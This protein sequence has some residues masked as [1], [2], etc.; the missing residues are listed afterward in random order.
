MANKLKNLNLTSVDLVRRG[1]NQEADICLFKSDLAQDGENPPS[2]HERNIFKQFINWLRKNPAEGDSTPSD[3]IEKDYSTFDA[4]NANRENQEKL[5]Q[6]TS[7]LTESIRTIVDDNSLD[8]AQKLEFMKKSLGQFDTAMEK[9][10][11]SL[12][13]M[14][15]VKQNVPD[16]VVKADS[17]YRYDVIQ[18]VKKFNPYHGKD[19][20]FS[21]ASGGGAT[22]F[23]IRTKDPN[24]QH[25]ADKAMMREAMRTTSI[26]VNGPSETKAFVDDYIKKHPEVAEEAKKYKDVLENVKN[27]QK[28]NPNAEAGTYSAVTGELVNP[29]SGFAVTFHQN[30]TANNPYGDYDSDTYAKMCA[31]TKRETGSKDVYIGFFGNAEVSFNCSSP[32]KAMEFAVKHNQNSIYNCSRDETVYNKKYNRKT[33]PIEG[34]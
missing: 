18:E 30:K 14:N 5:W 24:K 17:P 16:A 27:F 11:A 15:P 28:N 8:S 20:R 29:S 4:L 33:N 3:T 22:S 1:A 12:C 6:Y 26:A 25:L 13:T 19:G 32:G 10:F 23:T 21:S 2:E 9:L 7:S 31:I 34:Y